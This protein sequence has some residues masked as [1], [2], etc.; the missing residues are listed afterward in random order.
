MSDLEPDI[1]PET[2]PDHHTVGKRFRGWNLTK[3]EAAIFYCE[4]HDAAGY[5]MVTDDESY[6]TNV[7]E[8]AIGRTFHEIYE[9]YASNPEAGE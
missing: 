3:M 8:R 5:N 9:P 2:H 4:S 7:S 1:T 6:R